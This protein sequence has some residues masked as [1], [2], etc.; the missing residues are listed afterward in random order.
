MLIIEFNS[1]I[2][3]SLE[4]VAMNPTAY[5]Q[6]MSQS[7][8]EMLI[9]FEF[10]VCIPKEKISSLTPN[11]SAAKTWKKFKN[12]ESWDLSEWFDIDYPQDF[13]RWFKLRPG[14]EL[15]IP[16]K[17][18]YTSMHDAVIAYNELDDPKLAATRARRQRSG[19]W[20]GTRDDLW[21]LQI[22]ILKH[23][24]LW[25]EENFILAFDFDVKKVQDA[26]IKFE[27]ELSDTDY[28]YHGA[29]RVLAPAIKKYLSDGKKP[30][31]FGEYHEETKN[32]KRWYIEPDMSIG[33]KIVEDGTA[34]IVS[35]PLP[36]KKAVSALKGFYSMAADLNLYTNNSTGLHINIS[37]PQDIDILKLSLFLGDH[38]LLKYF[39][40]QNNSYAQS[41]IKDIE[42]KVD[43]IDDLINFSKEERIKIL[44]DIAEE[45]SQDHMA[46]V[47]AN[48][49]GEY[50]SFRHVGG[51]YL[52][53]YTKIF[54]TLGRLVRVMMI[55]SDPQAYRE[56]YLKKITKIMQA[57]LSQQQD[58]SKD[59]FSK[60]RE[61]LT[62]S[63]PNGFACI[64]VDIAR[65]STGWSNRTITDRRNSIQSILAKELS[66]PWSE[67]KSYSIGGESLT[68]KQNVKNNISKNYGVD[69][70][71]DDFNHLNS[72][73]SYLFSP[74]TP[75]AAL[76]MLKV[77]QE[78]FRSRALIRI[79]EI[80]SY[81]DYYGHLEI[82]RLPAND[83]KLRP[84][85]KN[86][87]SEIA[88]AKKKQ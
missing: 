85:L 68:A 6:S 45:F 59:V 77:N 52:S 72:A 86:I 11:W 46:S 49:D 38:Y 50:I 88:A 30:I 80:D 66:I 19:F 39:N 25:R 67:I 75:R 87:Q 14:K 10:E 57:T 33:A 9:G 29:V 4:E 34:E 71:V 12:L 53:D 15:S 8:K 44:R 16:G 5:A 35:P 41:I 40:R 13:D 79:P 58:P 21:S 32:L 7:P 22:R 69:T 43:D 47:S 61:L 76:A 20:N 62:A 83:P 37:V 3:Q 23:N 2:K 1:P 31:V 28:D 70:N 64:R 60:I 17:G 54:T 36:V 51:D 65:T 74:L 81:H 48:E 63:R 73:R 84:L 18:T 42:K 24:D 56:E 26:L 27:D 82:V 78:V 55:A